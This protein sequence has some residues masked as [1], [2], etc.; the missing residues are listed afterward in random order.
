MVLAEGSLSIV[1]TTRLRAR[2]D[3]KLSPVSEQSGQ[4]RFNLLDP[5][6]RQCYRIGL[7][8]RT[9]LAL[10]DGRRT[11]AQIL[12]ALHAESEYQGVGEHQLVELA[13]RLYQNGLIVPAEGESLRRPQAASSSPF[14][15][16]VVWQLRGFEPT[17][18]LRRLAPHTNLLFSRGA[19][20]FWMITAVVTCIAVMLEFPRLFSQATSWDW[21]IQ[22][23]QG[24]ALFVVFLL[25]RAL[26]E[27]G[28]AI[29]C[30]RHGVRCPDVGLFVILGAP[31]VYC[32]VSES[33]Q[34]PS[35]WQR[36][37]VAAAGMYVEIIVATLA[38]WVWMLTLDGVA[39]QLALQTMIVC[40]VSTLLINANPLMRFDGYYILS[41]LLDEPNLRARSDAAA[42]QQLFEVVLGIKSIAPGRERR[43]WLTWGMI[44]FSWLGWLYRAAMSLAMAAV[45]VTLYGYW[46]LAWLGRLVAIAILFSWWGVPSMKLA[47]ELFRAARRT[48]TSWRLAMASAVM[49]L[50]I[51]WVPIPYREFASGW[52]QPRHV[53]G[54]YA[55]QSGRLESQFTGELQHVETSQPL[56]RLASLSVEREA[57]SMKAA[58]ERARHRVDTERRKSLLQ[59]AQAID[60]APAQANLVAAAQQSRQAEQEVARLTLRAPCSGKLW[61]MPASRIQGPDADATVVRGTWEETTQLGRYVPQ[62]TMLAAVCSDSHMAIVPL[63]DQQL[64]WV[65]HGTRVRVCCASSPSEVF[66]SQVQSIVQ[67]REMDAI[68]RL[69]HESLAATNSG[70]SSTTEDIE[71][72]YAALVPVPD[73]MAAVVGTS[74][75][76]AFVAPSQTLANLGQR[77]LKHNLRWLAD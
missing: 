60:L 26:H 70:T 39:N 72:A 65:A 18:L 17:A 67:L 9:V 4:P 43:I 32:D 66:T 25:T 50:G 29:V 52:I 76:A 23:A 34:L 63:R 6:T 1:R 69:N 53:Q 77:W 16:L 28:H 22:P 20:R 73:D 46:N 55:S 2:R 19:C 36:M 15:S 42:T 3:L 47:Q 41:D 13:S 14:S 40:S 49:V 56:F 24:S 7:L 5:I 35:R 75:Q 58:E 27:L 8:E 64:E 57:M 21:I 44:A 12:H 59:D 74:V 54:V 61:I 51:A 30:Q 37:A 71:A 68:W 31:C 33:W 11:L 45:L 10:L 38:A 62:G 48:G